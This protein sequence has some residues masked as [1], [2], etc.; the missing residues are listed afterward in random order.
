VREVSEEN[1]RRPAQADRA[2]SGQRRFGCDEFKISIDGGSVLG[3]TCYD[4]KNPATLV[5]SGWVVR[6]RRK[7]RRGE[8]I[9]G[10]V[11]PQ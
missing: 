9:T 6:G 5:A 4:L 7:R 1:G 8:V 11:L 2:R 3:R 10:R